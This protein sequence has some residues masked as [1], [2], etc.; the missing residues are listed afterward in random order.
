MVKVFKNNLFWSG[1]LSVI[2]IT[3]SILSKWIEFLDLGI[4]NYSLLLI[5]FILLPNVKT[6]CREIKNSEI[7]KIKLPFCELK[8][9]KKY[10]YYFVGYRK[11]NESDG[12][13]VVLEF[14]KNILNEEEAVALF[15][16][17]FPDDKSYKVTEIIKQVHYKKNDE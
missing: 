12:D 9:L 14:Y 10:D 5:L 8:L 11:E 1:F 16:S 13:L 15:K 2:V 17:D 4:F 3:S 6:I 7:E